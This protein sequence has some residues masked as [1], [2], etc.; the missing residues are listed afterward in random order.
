M[1][2]SMYLSVENTVHTTSALFIGQQAASACASMKLAANVVPMFSSIK[3]QKSDNFHIESGTRIDILDIGQNRKDD[4][5][6]LWKRLQDVL[7]IGCVYLEILDF[8]GCIIDWHYYRS[9]FKL[10]HKSIRKCTC[11]TTSDNLDR[12]RYGLPLS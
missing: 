12:L 3:N 10:I 7:G 8:Q 11:E 6:Y 1:K 9:N 5:L 4:I 2:V